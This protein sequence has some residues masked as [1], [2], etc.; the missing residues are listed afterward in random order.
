MELDTGATVSLIS[1]ITYHKLWPESQQPQLHSSS[2]QLQTYT[3]EELAVR[4]SLS[5]E[6]C[7]KQQIKILPLLV[8]AGQGPSL[9]DRDWLE[10]KSV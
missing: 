7:Y 1:E 4:G 8:V 2:R 3:G 10:E 6:V 5:I 9:L